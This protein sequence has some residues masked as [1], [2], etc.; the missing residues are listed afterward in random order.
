MAA[1][2][3]SLR[4]AD[5]VAAGVP[6]GWSYGLR[7]RVRF[8]EIDALNHVNH[9]AYLRWFENLRVGYLRAYGI[10]REAPDAGYTVVLRAIEAR[11]NAPMF[12]G[13]DYIV[14]TRTVSFR[15]TSFRMEYGVF[16]PDLRVEGAAVVVLLDRNG[17]KAPLTPGMIADFMRMDG[18]QPEG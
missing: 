17:A 8:A 13:E 16:A 12:L 18:A 3:V 15:R 7:D 2:L 6:A 1:F 14:T 5:L 10:L 4:G 11:Y 9:T